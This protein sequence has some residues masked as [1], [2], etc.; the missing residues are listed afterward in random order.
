M[1]DPVAQP[2][3]TA[4]PDDRTEL[5]D[6]AQAALRRAAAAGGL[7]PGQILGHTYE[8]LALLARGG[9]GAV[10]RAR[11][12]DLGSLHAIKVILPDLAEDPRVI[13]LFQEEANKLRRLRHDAIVAYEGLFKDENGARYLVMEYVDGPSLA[14]VLRDGPLD[15]ARL[16]QLRDRC[17]EGLGAAHAK[18]I[19]HRDISPDNIILVEGRAELAKI[20]DFGIAKSTNPG[21]R[22]II[23]R[24]FAGK[25]SFASP[26]Q[27]DMNG[28]A[29]DARS[30][31]YSLG[32]V[33][34]AAALGRPLDMGNSL[35]SVVEK[36]RT[37]PDLTGV[38]AEFRTEIA[39][40]LAPDPDDRPA[41][42]RD[43][44]ARLA[45]P[46]EPAV[47]G[48]PV[49]RGGIGQALAIITVFAVVGGALTWGFM[50]P[51]VKPPQPV[52]PTADTAP[53]AKPA[54]DPRDQ[55]LAALKA[56][57]GSFACA[58]LTAEPNAAG[59]ALAG[60]VGSSGDLDRLRRVAN[61]VTGSAVS[62]D[63]VKIYP[64][65]LCTLIGLLSGRP[66]VP[67]L[68]FDREPRLYHEGET[69][70]LTVTAPADL[71]GYLYVDY[72][73]TGGSVV[74]MLPAPG[75]PDNRVKPGQ[76]IMLGA[77]KQP[78]ER[79][80]TVGEPYGP[81]LVTVLASAKP[82]FGQARPE[83]EPAEPYFAELR[84]RLAGPQ[85]AAIAAGYAVFDT[86]K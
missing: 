35:T 8:I 34:A 19:I 42:F 46:A 63:P 9:M 30:D 82:L 37:M 1:S 58:G 61:G 51:M 83:E 27:L 84:A 56:S 31:I 11:H 3:G 67:A 65:P 6:P 72:Y 77:A 50:R 2:G 23:G 39:P 85:G 17:A 64:P 52:P 18:G 75:H 26:E 29:V 33:L 41:S 20:I 47:P 66:A 4:A 40:M 54:P 71:D 53:P 15:P 43:L 25:Y 81:N 24:D 13:S 70:V 44:L 22:T 36:R 14:Q 21:D 16:R 12:T 49:K 32:L 80:Y 74:H 55:A 5:A 57:F 68:R 69:I 62:L 7:A 45:A 78:G 38:P 79:T 60:F 86:E 48:T 76:K 10:Y 59:I 28:H 73:D